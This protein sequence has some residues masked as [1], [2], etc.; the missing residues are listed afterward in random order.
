MAVTQKQIADQLNLSQPLVAQALNGNV[1]V[2]EATRQRVQEMAREMGY[3]A[4]SNGAARALVARRHGNRSRTSTV[5]VLMGN[6]LFEGWPL[7]DVPFFKPLLRGI[8]MEALERD[9]DISFLMG[10]PNR[11]PRVVTQ[12][13]VDGAIV[14][15]NQPINALIRSLNWQAP[16][17]RVGDAASGEWSLMPRNREGIRLATQHLI[18]LGHT[19]IAYLGDI[20]DHLPDISY[21]ERLKGY[22]QALQENGLPLDDALIDAHVSAPTQEMGAAAMERLLK[23]TRDFTAMVCFTDTCAMG[24]IRRAQEMGLRVPHD[25][26]V[27]GFDD[28]AEE[29]SFAPRL[30][31]VHF[32]RLE[33][34]RRAVRLLCESIDAKEAGSEN[35]SSDAETM[36]VALKVRESSTRLSG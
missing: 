35:M 32:D 25:L 18:E 20:D 12:H 7:H 4:H 21:G 13:G 19:R 11:L 24:A 28:V 17:L 8:E 31:T 30:T 22:A 9:L 23:K 27:V 1:K 29:Y 14:I 2:A 5:A 15:Y 33:M 26:S 16:I 36:P 34:G 6:S 3:G 10:S